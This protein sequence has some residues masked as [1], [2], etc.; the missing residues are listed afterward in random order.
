[1]KLLSII[2]TIAFPTII[3]AQSNYHRGYVLKNNGDTVKG[4]INYRE[5]SQ[6]PK[7]IDFKIN[8]ADKQTLQFNP[9][10][11]KEFQ[12]AGMDTYIAYTGSISIDKTNFPDVPEGL[13]TAKK[14][15]TIFL[16]RLVTGKYLTL[17]QYRDEIKTRFFIAET[18]G[19]PVELKYHEYYNDLKQVINSDIYKGQLLLYINEITPGNSKL[20]GKVER[21]RYQQGNLELLVDEINNNR[22]TAGKKA[23]YRFF[24]G[25]AISS[26]DT[27]VND[28]DNADKVTLITH[29]TIL[30]KINLGIDLF[31]NPN[32]Q[33]LVFR[34]ELSFSY[35]SLRL[36]YPVTLNTV[37]SNS[38]YTF[39][40]YTATFTP[41]I[42]F[43]VYNKDNLKMY[44]DGGIGLNFS[45]YSN[46]KFTV[47]KF[48]AEVGATEI[49][50]YKL[51]PLWISFPIQA[52]VVLNRKVEFFFAYIPY[53]DYT[54]YSSFYAG[55][56]SMNLG[57]KFLFS[58][59]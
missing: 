20:I 51:N 46:N 13:D 43:N 42:L 37:T 52:G 3:F 45:A 49:P 39:N 33:Q 21:G 29:T 17:F 11:I 36:P 48:N 59:H 58:N 31:D 47:P 5:W 24:A 50:P 10:T 26:T 19:E 41:Q 23:S 22:I 16:K 9:Q 14:L 57:M 6:Q 30:P 40:Q 38:I 34:G 4:Y 2:L 27:K 25:I 12:V 32:V 53:A 44:I 56:S 54:S 18:N 1:M 35:I 55:N 15:D 8:E 7:S 28:I